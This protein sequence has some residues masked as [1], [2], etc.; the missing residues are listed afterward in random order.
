[1]YEAYIKKEFLKNRLHK[2][3]KV[4]TGCMNRLGFHSIWRIKMHLL[5]LIPPPPSI[6]YASW[7]YKS[8]AESLRW[9]SK[10]LVLNISVTIYLCYSTLQIQCSPFIQRNFV[11]YSEKFYCNSTLLL[12]NLNAQHSRYKCWHGMIWFGYNTKL[13]L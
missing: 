5:L 8:I 9:W 3:F 11:V 12:P 10:T 1:M 7:I 2:L 13:Q 4:Y 6:Q